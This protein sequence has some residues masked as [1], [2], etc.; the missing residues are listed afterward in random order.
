LNAAPSGKT[1]YLAAAR[2]SA[3]AAD[4]TRAGHAE[5]IGS[6][7]LPATQM[8]AARK[9]KMLSAALLAAIVLLAITALGLNAML[10]GSTVGGNASPRLSGVKTIQG[11]Q[12][13]LRLAGRP[14]G[15][16][17]HIS[18]RAPVIPAVALAGT[19]LHPTSTAA[20]GNDTVTGAA[21]PQS[22][23][24]ESTSVESPIHADL[25][26]IESLATS[27]NARAQMLLGLYDLHDQGDHQ[28]SAQAAKWLELAA[29]HGEPVAQYRLGTMYAKGIGMPANAAKAFHWY[30]AA[31]EAGNLKA[32]QNLGLAYVQGQGTAKNVHE[33]VSWFTRAANL[34]LVDAQFNLAVLYEQGFGVT[35]SLRQA[36]QWF[37]IAAKYGDQESKSRVEALSTQIPDSDR[38]AAEK[39]IADF[40]PSA[41]DAH[42]NAI[43]ELSST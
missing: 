11:G 13:S 33:A 36:Y 39:A 5:S 23:V 6:S 21:A 14:V 16:V 20:A 37:G 31:A 29:T 19:T 10:K 38:A 26:R 27:G 12:H 18:S 22:Q 30:Q 34:G 15:H 9:G 43:P 24:R 42:A 2:Q 7:L 35:L 8:F 17:L 25:A 32:M 1:D 3:R 28:Q 41:M 40:K 4:N